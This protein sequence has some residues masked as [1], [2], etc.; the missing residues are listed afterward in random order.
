MQDEETY[1]SENDYKT[2]KVSV[3]EKLGPMLLG[4]IGLGIALVLLIILYI[5]TRVYRLAKLMQIFD[6][7]YYQVFWN[8]PFRYLMESY[9]SITLT[10]LSLLATDD[11]LWADT[12]SRIQTL[13]SS[14]LMAL[15]VIAPFAMTSYFVKNINKF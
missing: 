4:L 3:Y 9:L 11:N 12:W 6:Y 7:L 8:A 1:L 14:S 13:F 2:V 5:I 10:T 15:Y